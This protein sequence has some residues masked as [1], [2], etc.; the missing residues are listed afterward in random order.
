MRKIKFRAWDKNRGTIDPKE[1]IK[2]LKKAVNYWAKR[3]EKLEAA[4]HRIA[5][6]TT[7]DDLAEIAKEA[8][9]GKGGASE[10]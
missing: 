9:Y 10:K 7:S 8:L 1:D 4:L 6:E 3:T 5:I 2:M